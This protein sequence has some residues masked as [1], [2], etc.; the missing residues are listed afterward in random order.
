M[1]KIDKY[2][3][4]N[5]LTNPKKRDIIIER[6]H[7]GPLVK[8]LRHGPLKAET[9][10]RFS[11]GSPRQ[12]PR[13]RCL[14]F[15]VGTREENRSAPQCRAQGAGVR[16]CA[17]ERVELAHKRQGAKIFAFSEI[18]TTTDTQRRVSVFFYASCLQAQ[19]KSFFSH[20]LH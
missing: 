10:V 9:G 2:F 14:F 4:K 13:K 17:A 8:R 1:R 6:M 20:A 18:L 11:H 3:F 12:T 7:H 5:L 16:I 19:R 15:V